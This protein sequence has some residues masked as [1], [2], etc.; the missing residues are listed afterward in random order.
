M[1]A[2][3]R[4]AVSDLGAIMA[5]PKNDKHCEYSRYAEHSLEMVR[6]ATDRKSRIIQREMAAEWFKLADAIPSQSQK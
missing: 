4:A 1:C 3:C 2:D 5:I 6:I